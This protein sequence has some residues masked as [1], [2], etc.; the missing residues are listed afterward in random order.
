MAVEMPSMHR[1][2]SKS[3]VARN[4]SPALVIMIS[5][6][7]PPTSTYRSAEHGFVDPI[8]LCL[9]HEHGSISPNARAQG[10][11]IDSKAVKKHKND[12]FRLFQ[13]LDPSI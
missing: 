8:S 10:E 7:A 3:F 12:V 1:T 9:S 13:I 6:A 5:Q 4:S 11:E 2:M